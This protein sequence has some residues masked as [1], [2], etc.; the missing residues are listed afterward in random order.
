MATAQLLTGTPSSL[1]VSG[2]VKAGAGYGG[3]QTFDSRALASDKQ[4]TMGHVTGGDLTIGNILSGG[5]TPQTWEW[6]FA[7]PEWAAG[8]TYSQNQIVRYLGLGYRFLPVGPIQDT[9]GPPPS[10]NWALLD[11]AGSPAGPVLRSNVYVSPIQMSL[12][13]AGPSTMELNIQGGPDSSMTIVGTSLDG[14]T[15]KDHVVRSKGYISCEG[16]QITNTKY[17]A[18]PS[19]GTGTLDAIGTLVIATAA[20]DPAARIFVTPTSAGGGSL[21]VTNKLANSFAV[22]SSAGV[23]DAGRTFDWWIVNPLW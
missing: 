23:A 6:E 18:N 22:T 4:L 19:I 3:L 15:S 11:A 17:A 13:G 1:V 12:G 14:V 10:A 16:L 9:L 8:Q 20:S 2:S 7:V 21:Y 5:T